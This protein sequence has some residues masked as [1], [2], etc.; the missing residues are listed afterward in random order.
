MQDT[1]RSKMHQP[2]PL[3]S[4][5]FSPSNITLLHFHSEMQIHFYHQMHVSDLEGMRHCLKERKLNCTC[6]SVMFSL[7]SVSVLYLYYM[8][9]TCFALTLCDVDVRH[10]SSLLEKSSGIAVAAFICGMHMSYSGIHVY[11]CLLS[12][13]SSC[14]I[15]STVLQI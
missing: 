15:I 9:G 14:L 2:V 10:I 8:V 6:I 13:L 11:S 4:C 7:Y 5:F 3:T 1:T 12:F